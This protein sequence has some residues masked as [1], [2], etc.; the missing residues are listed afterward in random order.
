MKSLRRRR[1]SIGR[2]WSGSWAEVSM[3]EVEQLPLFSHVPTPVPSDRVVFKETHSDYVVYVD[4][5]G[6]HSLSSV[7]KNYPIF[8][9]AFCV[10]YKSHYAS[11]VVPMLERF[12]FRH[13]GH[14]MVILHESDIRKEIDPFNIFPNREEHQKFIDEL[15]GVINGVNFILISCVID[16]RRFAAKSSTDLNPYHIALASCLES[17]HELM[18]EKRQEKLKT[19]VVMEC[20]GKKEDA[21]LELEFRRICDGENRF[22]IPLSFSPILADKRSNS[23]GLQLADLVA[24]PIGRHILDMSQ[25]NRAFEVLKPKF[26]CKGGRRNLGKDYFGLGLKIHPYPESEKPR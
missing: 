15:T 1:P 22:G 18:V 24:R 20:R 17:L 12:K 10:F 2:R 6:D 11:V 14:D 26:F 19:H 8:V 25:K 21:A 13:F 7:D 3:N 9:L 23:S 5:S 4:E 16:K